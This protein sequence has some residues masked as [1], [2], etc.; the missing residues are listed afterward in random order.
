[1]VPGDRQIIDMGYT[2]NLKN[3]L[4]FIVTEKSGSAKPDIPYLSKYTDQF[5]NVST[6]PVACPLVI[7]KK[8]CC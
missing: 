3:I 1:M 7:S 6:C 4:S 8:I 5:T 2:Y